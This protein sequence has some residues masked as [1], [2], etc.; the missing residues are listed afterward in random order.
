MM[1]N[2]LFQLWQNQIGNELH[3]ANLYMAVSAFF[4]QKG[5]GNLSNFFYEHA[6]EER[7]HADYIMKFLMSSGNFPNEIPAIPVVSTSFKSCSAAMET[8]A[9]HERLV[10]EQIDGIASAAAADNNHASYSAIK[11]L[12]D[13]QVEELDWSSKLVLNIARAEATNTLHLLDQ[14]YSE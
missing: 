13:E 2:K 3:S 6:V 1:K 14:E 10:T 12:V 7:G 8:V 11:T 5:L 4:D 9:A